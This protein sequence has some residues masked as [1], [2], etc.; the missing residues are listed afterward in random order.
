MPKDSKRQRYK[1]L[2]SQLRPHLTN[3]N[4]YRN[5]AKQVETLTER[6]QSLERS[7][8]LSR[9][10]AS[11]NSQFAYDDYS[12]PLPPKGTGSQ[13]SSVGVASP[14]NASLSPDDCFNTR[15]DIFGL[16]S[17][18]SDKEHLPIDFFGA[19]SF[20][21]NS[22]YNLVSPFTGNLPSSLKLP[23]NAS[24]RQMHSFDQT[25]DTDYSQD[26]RRLPNTTQSSNDFDTAGSGEPQKL[27]HNVAQRPCSDI[28]EAVV[29]YLIDLYFRRFQILMEIVPEKDFMEQMRLGSGPAY[30]ES[31]LLAVLA[32]GYR[33]S[34]QNEHTAPYMLPNGDNVFVQRATNLLESEL[35]HSNITTVQALL[36]L[37]ELQ[38]SAGNDMTGCSLAG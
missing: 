26:S 34:T 9:A 25:P 38:T 31:L 37:G 32:A 14:P 15:A 33:Y 16:P 11:G 24:F 27:V 5:S 4:D 18:G 28:P 17:D 22:N 3:L 29:D 10:E 30:R 1:L 6:V 2:C 19:Q 35:R 12:E 20:D 13:P 21:P 36:I 8:A 23:S 7:L